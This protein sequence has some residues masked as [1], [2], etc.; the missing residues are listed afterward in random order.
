MTTVNRCLVL[1]RNTDRTDENA[2]VINGD[3]RI[4]IEQIRRNKVKVKIIELSLNKYPVQRAE[5]C[6]LSSKQTTA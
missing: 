2:F 3:L 4:E 1:T 6:G 5:L